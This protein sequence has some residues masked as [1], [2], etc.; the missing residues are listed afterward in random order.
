MLIVIVFLSVISYNYVLNRII[1]NMIFIS[2][3]LTYISYDIIYFIV[4]YEMILV[5]ISVLVISAGSSLKKEGLLKLMYYTLIGSVFL[6]VLIG[7]ILS[8]DNQS[9]NYYYA[10]MKLNYILI[11]IR[12]V[13]KFRIYRFLT[14]LLSAL[15]ESNIIGSIILSGLILKVSI[16]G[17][18]RYNFGVRIGWYE[19]VLVVLGIVSVLISSLYSI[20]STDIKRI[21]AY[22]SVILMSIIFISVLLDEKI[23]SWL[24]SITLS[25]ISSS[26][27]Y[28]VSLLYLLY[29]SRNVLYMRLLYC[30]YVFFGL[31]FY[32]MLSNISFRFTCAFAREFIIFLLLMQNIG[33]MTIIVIVTVFLSSVLSIWLNTKILFNIKSI[34]LIKY[35]DLNRFLTY[36]LAAFCIVNLM[37]SININI[38]STFLL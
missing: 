31:F 27:F 17:W 1:Y 13:M 22:C 24:I 20:I 16:W 3:Y 11:S 7:L 21:I 29:L 25:F 38:F 33:K 9:N 30:N 18:F 5:R 32:L 23:G 8:G 10:R 19:K 2:M 15:T 37:S 12:L 36:N 14:W 35:I 34:Y 26:L 6:I 4:C 28:I